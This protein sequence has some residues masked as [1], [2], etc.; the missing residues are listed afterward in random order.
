MKVKI[1]QILGWIFLVF[2]IF[3]SIYSLTSAK[4]PIGILPVVFALYISN[5]PGWIGLILLWR[6]DKNK[7]P[8]KKSI[9]GII[10]IVL[11]I[12]WLFI[13]L[14]LI[15]LIIKYGDSA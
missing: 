15:Y 10:L 12:P 2:G 6:A 7:K 4:G 13:V 8:D 5:L 9:W 11:F 1:Y 14:S 3:N